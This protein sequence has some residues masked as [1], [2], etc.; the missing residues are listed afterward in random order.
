MTTTLLQ[1]CSSRLFCCR[2]FQFGYII[3]VIQAIRLAK[4][5]AWSAVRTNDPPAHHAAGGLGGSPEAVSSMQV[6]KMPADSKL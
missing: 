6:V 2:S 5:E 1:L 4:G 3:S